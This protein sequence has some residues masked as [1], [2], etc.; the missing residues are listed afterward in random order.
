M[1]RWAGGRE[2][3]PW[4]GPPLAMPAAPHA[5]VCFPDPPELGPPSAAAMRYAP[6]IKK[7]PPHLLKKFAVCDIPLYDI[8]DYNVS[9]DRCKELGCCFYKG[10]CYEKAVPGEYHG[11]RRRLGVGVTP[12]AW[13]VP[14]PSQGPQNPVVPAPCRSLGVRTQH[15]SHSCRD[16]VTAGHQD[17]A[18]IQPRTLRVTESLESAP[19]S[20]RPGGI[21]GW[22]RAVGP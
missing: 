15:H 10:V 19:Q 2:G 18:A 17:R 9:R 8:C 16:R 22:G 14:R 3:V 6:E 11:R 5:C 7:S 12:R 20:L 4:P 21:V 1:C 13:H